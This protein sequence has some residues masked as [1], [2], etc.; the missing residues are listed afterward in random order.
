MKYSFYQLG[1][2]WASNTGQTATPTAEE[3]RT[4][5]QKSINYSAN[6]V[7]DKDVEDFRLGAASVTI[8]AE[9]EAPVEEKPKRKYT[10]RTKA[11]TE[12]VETPEEETDEESTEDTTEEAE[13]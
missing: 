12:V 3:V 13:G 9:V 7:T 6:R 8:P 10:K 2:Q 1:Q 4:H 11:T 5:I